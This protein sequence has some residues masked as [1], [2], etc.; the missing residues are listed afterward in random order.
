MRNPEDI[1]NVV[2]AVAG[3]G[4]DGKRPAF[5]SQGPV[6]WNTDYYKDGKVDKPD[7]TTLNAKIPCVDPEGNLT[8]IAGGNSLSAPH[9]AG[10]V[11]L[12][13]SA[14]P[15]LLP[16]KI[17]EILL[18]TAKDLGDKGFDYQHGH[19]YVNAYDA[20]KAAMKR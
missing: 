8:I 12:M 15:D 6:E 11:S 5:S 20:V 2:L 18:N 13:F 1:P 4:E 9:M 3:V 10:I 19:G 16:W 17:K 14:N 7:F